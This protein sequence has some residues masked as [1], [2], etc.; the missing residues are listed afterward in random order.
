MCLLLLSTAVN[1]AN[2]ISE[3]G[4]RTVTDREPDFRLLESVLSTLAGKVGRVWCL[5]NL[6]KNSV[7]FVPGKG[8]QRLS[9]NIA[10][11]TDCQRERGC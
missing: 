1:G 5:C 3:Q 6:A 10:G 8:S 4:R 9:A 7:H 2:L 11:G